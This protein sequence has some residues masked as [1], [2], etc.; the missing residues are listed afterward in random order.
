VQH[1]RC[2]WGLA[3]LEQRAGRPAVARQGFERAAGLLA[4]EPHEPAQLRVL[5]AGLATEAAP[6]A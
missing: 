4:H 3:L 2:L 5:R 6:S 1:A